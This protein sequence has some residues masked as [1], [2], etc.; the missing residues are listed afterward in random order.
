[1]EGRRKVD[2]WEEG[3]GLVKEIT[4]LSW[5]NDVL[6]YDM[7]GIDHAKIR[8]RDQNEASG[9]ETEEES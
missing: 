4:R 7:K 8:G 9:I 1:M 6:R 2:G 3:G 5:A